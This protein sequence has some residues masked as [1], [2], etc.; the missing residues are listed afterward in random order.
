MWT[1]CEKF[2]HNYSYTTLKSERGLDSVISFIVYNFLF[3]QWKK[4]ERKVEI[5]L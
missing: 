2:L 4:E 3:W 1:L 5:Q